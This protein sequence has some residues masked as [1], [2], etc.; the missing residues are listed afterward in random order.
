MR[1]TRLLPMLLSAAVLLAAPALGSALQ[2]CRPGPQ[3]QVLHPTP[4]ATVPTNAVVFLLAG[5]DRRIR[6]ADQDSGALIA[7]RV[8][9]QGLLWRLVPESPLPAGR[10]FRVELGGPQSEKFSPL[11]TFRTGQDRAAADVPGLKAARLS[12]TPW[13]PKSYFRRGGRRVWTGGGGRG[14]TLNLEAGEVAPAVV[15]ARVE[16]MV[17]PSQT[18]AHVVGAAMTPSWTLGTYGP[19]RGGFMPSVP[20]QGQYRVALIPWSGTGSSGEA[21]VLRG[22]IR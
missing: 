5:S 10:R 16:W 14:A 17:G 21:W 1:P 3:A 7:V 4:E 11:T 15:E 8:H 2:P 22:R 9:R 13:Q 20:R 12:F 6:I 18:S 19:C